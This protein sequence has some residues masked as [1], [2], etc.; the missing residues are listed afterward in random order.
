MNLPHEQKLYSIEESKDIALKI[1][2][3]ISEN[4][5]IVLNGN[6]GSGKTT[7]IKFICSN[8][9]IAD[10]SSPSF[11]IVNEYY[12]SKKIFH[13]DFYRIKKIEELYDIGIEEYFN[14][15][16]AIV[17]IEWGNLM[18]DILPLKHYEINLKL[19]SDNTRQIKIFKKN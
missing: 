4:D 10:V 18:Q 19:A 13:F 5:V 12:G 9:N 11:S 17:F 14:D 15:Q 1:S 7:L 3:I 6:L 2:K 8:F 16:E